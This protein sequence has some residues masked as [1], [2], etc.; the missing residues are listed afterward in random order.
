MPKAIVACDFFG[1]MTATFRL[2]HVLIVIDHGSRRLLHFDVTEHPSADWTLQQLREVIEDE[3]GHRYLLYDRDRIFAWG[4]DESIKRL[5]LRVLKSPPHSPQASAICERLIGTARR[6]CLDW[7][8]PLS[9]THL[10]S[11]LKEWATHNHATRPHMMLGPGVPDPPAG[12]ARGAD[13]TSR[14]CPGAHTA[15]YARSV[16]G[17]LHHEYSIAPALA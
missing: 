4:P 5:G 1:A 16:L 3:A 10:R 9:E 17:R 14:H 15:V 2:L 7:L 6:V 11:L 8:I 12:T 13:N